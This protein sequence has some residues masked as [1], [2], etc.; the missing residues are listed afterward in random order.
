MRCRSSSA[1][2]RTRSSP[3][4][5]GVDAKRRQLPRG[6]HACCPEWPTTSSLRRRGSRVEEATGDGPASCE[7][8]RRR[9]SRRGEAPRAAAAGRQGPHG[10]ERAHDRRHGQGARSVLGRRDWA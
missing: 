2:R 5:Y 1:P 7:A 4:T 10:L 3:P 8:R 9:S 6:G